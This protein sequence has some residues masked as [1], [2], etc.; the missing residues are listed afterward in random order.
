MERVH[1]K[2]DPRDSSDDSAEVEIFMNA[3]IMC[4][5]ADRQNGV[6]HAMLGPAYV[7]FNESLPSLGAQKKNSKTGMNRLVS[8]D[9]FPAEVDKAYSMVLLSMKYPNS[10][11]MKANESID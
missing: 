2:K 10:H 7:K 9:N 1:F 4:E 3:Q 11:I 6:R 8:L 5:S